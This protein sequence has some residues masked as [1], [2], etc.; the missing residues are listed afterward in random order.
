MRVRGDRSL[1]NALFLYKFFAQITSGFVAVQSVFSLLAL[2]IL[3]SLVLCTVVR[4]NQ[5]Y[6]KAVPNEI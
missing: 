6:C 5:K 2:R 4:T 3:F 1:P